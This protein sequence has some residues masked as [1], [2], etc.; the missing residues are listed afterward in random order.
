LKG[1]TLFE[2]DEM[3]GVPGFGDAMELVGW[4]EETDEGVVLINFS[5][6][7]TVGTERS[8]VAKTGAERTKGW[9]EKQK[10]KP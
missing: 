2:I 7:N 6:H 8:S 4:V 3:A 5:E 10:I 1:S 9:R